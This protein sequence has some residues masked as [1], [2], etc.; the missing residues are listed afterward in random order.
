MNDLQIRTALKRKALVRYEKDPETVIL[1]ELGLRHGAARIDIAVVNGRLHGFEIKSDRDTLNRLP[2]QAKIFNSVLDRI[3]LI[4]TQR[5]VHAAKE[6]VPVWWGI[7]LAEKGSRGAVHFSSIR[8]PRNNPCPNIEAVA[9]LL[10]RD[11]AL[12]LLEEIGAAKG[13]R[14]KPR[15]VLY[16]RL[17]KV[18]DLKRVRSRVI[19]QL[20]CREDWRSD[21]RRKL[22]DG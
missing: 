19:R 15:S 9:K 5:H 6:V 14:T 22:D 20:K 12:A 11:E 17:A 21:V 1:D 2:Y 4:V 18:A 3:T 16:A 7:M 8:R 13:V 10:W